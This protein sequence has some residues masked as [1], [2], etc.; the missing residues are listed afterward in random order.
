M[1]TKF[2]ALVIEHEPSPY[3]HVNF[4]C[5]DPKGWVLGY[6]RVNDIINASFFGTKR[7][8]EDVLYNLGHYTHEDVSKI[9]IALINTTIEKYL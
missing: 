4:E 6:D 1:I 7:E 8:A 3:I 2:Y 9:K 5:G